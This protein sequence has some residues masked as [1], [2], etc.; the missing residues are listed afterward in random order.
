MA[1]LLNFE[2]SYFY[3][4]FISAVKFCGIE[5]IWSPL[6]F[7]FFTIKEDRMQ[8]KEGEYEQAIW[9]K[10]SHEHSKSELN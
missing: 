10:E 3:C 6:A 8:L 5:E 2:D 7:T 4:S 1:T 9:K